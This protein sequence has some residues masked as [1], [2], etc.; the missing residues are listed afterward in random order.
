MLWSFFSLKKFRRILLFLWLCIDFVC[1]VALDRSEC[2]IETHLLWMHS[3]TLIQIYDLSITYGCVFVSFYPSDYKNTKKKR[4]NF[5]H[6]NNATFYCSTL[7][8]NLL[9]YLMHRCSILSI[10]SRVRKRNRSYFLNAHSIPFHILFL[11]GALFY[12]KYNLITLHTLLLLLLNYLFAFELSN[13]MCDFYSFLLCYNAMRC[14]AIRCDTWT[15][16]AIPSLW[17]GG[18]RWKCSI[19]S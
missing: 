15:H 8:F 5:V 17:C 6:R 18:N 1:F 16:A 19:Q 11:L 2:D 13:E 4:F 7:L 9:I 10:R 3:G 14:D 12:T